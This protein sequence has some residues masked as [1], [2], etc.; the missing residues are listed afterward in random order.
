M[1]IEGKLIKNV[2]EDNSFSWAIGLKY[3]TNGI[4]TSACIVGMS[5][6]EYVTLKSSLS[7]KEFFLLLESNRLPDTATE[8][9]NKGDNESITIGLSMAS[10]ESY[11][12][13]DR[14]R[15]LSFLNSE[16]EITLLA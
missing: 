15:L 5:D 11:F 6:D 10:G 12:F 1:N 14:V 9:N 13:I 16:P 3:F 4:L 8:I 7:Y 2:Y